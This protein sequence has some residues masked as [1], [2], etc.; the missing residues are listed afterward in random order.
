[1]FLG[2]QDLEST[3][4]LVEFD[5]TCLKDSIKSNSMVFDRLSVIFP[6]ALLC[7][8]IKDKSNLTQGKYIWCCFIAGKN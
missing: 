3:Q 8:T 1:M 6:K 2:P 5:P 4:H 7:N